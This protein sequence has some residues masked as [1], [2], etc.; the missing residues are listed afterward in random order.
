MRFFLFRLRKNARTRL[1][2]PRWFHRSLKMRRRS[3]PTLS[4]PGWSIFYRVSGS[5]IRNLKKMHESEKLDFIFACLP[6]LSFFQAHILALLAKSFLEN[7]YI[8]LQQFSK[9]EIF[10]RF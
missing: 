4:V 7:E 10:D 2:L 3:S 1:V 8:I 5:K 9:K 6:H